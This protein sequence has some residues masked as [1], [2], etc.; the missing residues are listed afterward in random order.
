MYQ[1][2]LNDRCGPWDGWTVDWS[3]SM[4]PMTTKASLLPTVCVVQEQSTC[5]C[6]L[7]WHSSLEP[8]VSI[9]GKLATVVIR[10]GNLSKRCTNTLNR[11]SVLVVAWTAFCHPGMFG[12]LNVCNFLKG[13][14]HL[15]TSCER[16][17]GYVSV[18]ERRYRCLI[19]LT[20]G[21]W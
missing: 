5:I 1:I 19:V 9:H 7:Q 13:M 10:N 2:H 3:R 17:L 16:V 11:H 6:T 20:I 8:S 12:A 18:L 15:L 14:D 21:R 4:P